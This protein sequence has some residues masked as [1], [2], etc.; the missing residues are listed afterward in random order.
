MTITYLSPSIQN[1]LDL[2]LSKKVKNIILQEVR[3]AKYFCDYMRQYSG[4]ITY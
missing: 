2:L 4:H 1:E 3:E